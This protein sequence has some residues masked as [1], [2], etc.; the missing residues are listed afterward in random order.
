MRVLLKVSMPVESANEV[1]RSGRLGETIQSILADQKPEAAYFIEMD[2]RRTGIIVVDVQEASQIPALAE[3]W[4][5]AFNAH[6][7]FH[8][9]MTPADLEKAGPAIEQAVRTYGRTGSPAL[10]G[11]SKT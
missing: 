9:A 7:E 1:I 4:F 8:P 2:G 6:V 3:P 5:L 11:A 10:T